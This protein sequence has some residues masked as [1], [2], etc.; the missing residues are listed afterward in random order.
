MSPNLSSSQNTLDGLIALQVRE[1][2]VFVNVT[3][4]SCLPSCWPPSSL[5]WVRGDWAWVWEPYPYLQHPTGYCSGQGSSGRCQSHPLWNVLLSSYSALTPV[6]ENLNTRRA[7][8]DHQNN[9]NHRRFLVLQFPPHLILDD[10]NHWPPQKLPH[11]HQGL[12]RA[13]DGC[14]SPQP[15]AGLWGFCLCTLCTGTA[16]GA[17]SSPDPLPHFR[18]DLPWSGTLVHLQRQQ[19]G[20]VVIRPSTI[21]CWLP[22][23]VY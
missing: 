5:V 11:V 18:G 20:T 3:V 13:P 6:E 21:I 7:K 23:G 22:T 8:S 2:Y 4:P 16:W 15:S 19:K 14:V 17:E 1:K 9:T 10:D 12:A